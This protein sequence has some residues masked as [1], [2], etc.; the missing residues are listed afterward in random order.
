MILMGGEV[1]LAMMQG[2]GGGGVDCTFEWA[3]LCEYR[4]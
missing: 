3:L 1:I 2:C 4:G